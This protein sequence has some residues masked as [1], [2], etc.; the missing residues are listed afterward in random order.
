MN[1]NN[2]PVF[3]VA[4]ESAENLINYF[5][6]HYK[7][8]KIPKICKGKFLINVFQERNNDKKLL[9]YVEQS[10]KFTSVSV[11]KNNRV[12]TTV[13]FNELNLELILE[14]NQYFITYEK[15]NSFDSQFQL[16]DEE[17]L[18]YIQPYIITTFFIST[19]FDKL[20]YKVTVNSSKK[21]ENT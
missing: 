7:G 2:L 10:D 13:S 6:Y 17:N 21:R 11:I 15:E 9:L 12:C 20:D 3:N 16:K 5:F 8:N 19:F 4:E 18:E 14:N 1:F